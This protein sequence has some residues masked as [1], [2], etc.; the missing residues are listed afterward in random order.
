LVVAVLHRDTLLTR[1]DVELLCGHDGWCVL[2]DTVVAE[3]GPFH[4]WGELPEY[5]ERLRA[6]G[7]APIADQLEARWPDAAAGGRPAKNK[8]F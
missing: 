8:M 4:V 5:L 7:R 6:T 3:G 1:S 2:L